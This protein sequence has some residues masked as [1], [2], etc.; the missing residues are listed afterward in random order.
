[1][2]CY[3]YMDLHWG[4]DSLLSGW[5]K[6]SS[7]QDFNDPFECQGNVC[8]TPPRESLRN[9]CRGL[10]RPAH[11][12]EEDVLDKVHRDFL[13]KF[14]HELRTRK[15]LGDRF[16]VLCMSS[17]EETTPDAE[18]LMWGH[19]ADGGKGVRIVIDTDLCLSDAWAI[20]PVTYARNAE[21]PL[22]DLSQ[23]KDFPRD[24]SL[25][26]F[27]ARCIFT[28]GPMWSYENERRLIAHKARLLPCDYK[29]ADNGTELIKLPRESILGI[30]FGVWVTEAEVRSA[31]DSIRKA[32]LT[33]S[34]RWAQF[35]ADA[36]R[37]IY[38]S[39]SEA[40]FCEESGAEL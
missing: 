14:A 2:R 29:L 25:V 5:F 27:Y 37:Y 8:G 34:I 26:E 22:Y 40:G 35:S 13:C 19:Y 17:A 18:T 38:W 23:L 36:Y 7:P 12:N 21:L 31:I 20:Q 11:V 32:G 24:S 30:E 15:P 3:R 16:R 9:F 33:I 10:V 39:W 1:M 28:K 6:V 4:I